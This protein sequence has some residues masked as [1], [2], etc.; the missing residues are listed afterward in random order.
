MSEAENKGSARKG[1]SSRGSSSEGSDGEVTDGQ[2]G[3]E[4]WTDM[5]Q[6]CRAGQG[7]DRS[8]ACTQL[9]SDTRCEVC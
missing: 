1:M 7:S 9:A 8:D 4:G 5:R 2:V 3:W 6:A